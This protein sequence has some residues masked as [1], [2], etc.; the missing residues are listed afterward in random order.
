MGF[1]SPNPEG[2]NR[3]IAVLA[4]LQHGEKSFLGNID[5]TD[6]FHSFFAFLLFFEELAFARKAEV[7]D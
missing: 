1:A 2:G 4:D 3:L 5:A 7:Y 6:A